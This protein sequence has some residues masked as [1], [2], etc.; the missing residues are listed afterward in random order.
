M[1]TLQLFFIFLCLLPLFTIAQTTNTVAAINTIDFISDTQQPMMVE[2][3]VLKS[4]NNI[5]ATALI[6]ANIVKT[7]PQ[8]VYMLGDIVSLGFRNHKWRKVDKFLSN[9]RNENTLVCGLLGNHDVMGRKRKG[10]RNF[11][12]RFPQN[13]RTGYVS[14]TDSVAVI[15]LNSNFNTLTSPDKKKQDDWYQETLNLL[16]SNEAIKAVIVTCHHAPFS[17]SKIVGS[18]ES[19]QHNFV[20]PYIKSKKAQ[21]FITGHSHNFEHFNLLGKDFLVIGGGGGLHQPININNKNLPDL[22]PD[23]KPLFHYLSVNRVD[24]VLKVTSHYLDN[25]FIDFGLGHSF[26]TTAI[27]KE[28]RGN[29]S[30]LGQLNQINTN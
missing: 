7:K 12:K 10:E 21:L 14:V 15:L 2:K 9:C 16:D 25:K 27:P 3:L 29:L 8:S 24:N 19:V 4:D 28:Y 26:T 30:L 18:S 11:D 6:F 17:N 5:K 1:K 22:A 20:M 23:Y 13:V